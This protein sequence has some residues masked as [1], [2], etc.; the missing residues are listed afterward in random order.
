MIS[1]IR[2]NFSKP[3]T[4]Y[5]GKLQITQPNRSSHLQLCEK[6]VVYFICSWQ[7]NYFHLIILA[8]NQVGIEGILFFG[9]L[10]HYKNIPMDPHCQIV[11]SYTPTERSTLG[12]SEGL[13]GDIWTLLFSSQVNF[14]L[15]KKFPVDMNKAV[16]RADFPW[17]V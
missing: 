11:V 3:R 8:G 13:L 6:H 4:K 9:G 5:V 14:N 16:S 2:I 12:V 10:D 15:E 7:P 17:V 1:I